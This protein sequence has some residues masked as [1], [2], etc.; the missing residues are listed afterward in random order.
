MEQG[1]RESKSE[2]ESGDYLAV[3][4][5]TPEQ[6]AR[7]YPSNLTFEVS[8]VSLLAFIA[9]YAPSTLPMPFCDELHRSMQT[10]LGPALFPL[11]DLSPYFLYMV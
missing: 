5:P 6:K 7:S 10:C 11:V 9:K 1:A 8:K 2:S 4:K 3:S